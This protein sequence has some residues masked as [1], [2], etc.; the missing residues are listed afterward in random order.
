MTEPRQRTVQT[1]LNGSSLLDAGPAR[2]MPSAYILR[3]S[4]PTDDCSNSL[5]A[6]AYVIRRHK[7]RSRRGRAGQLNS[8]GN[9]GVGTVP[10][11]P[12]DSYL[13]HLPLT[14]V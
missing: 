4:N 11:L 9:R 2:P 13:R 6:I 7:A 12:P 8:Y 3:S 10:P 1:T 5:L 14:N